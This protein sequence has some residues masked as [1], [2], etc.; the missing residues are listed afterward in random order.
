MDGQYILLIIGVLC[1]DGPY[2]YSTC[3][4][5]EEEEFNLLAFWEQLNEIKLEG[6]HMNAVLRR[7][8]FS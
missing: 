2:E 1:A 7:Q 4:E 3:T 8:G 6:N 5:C